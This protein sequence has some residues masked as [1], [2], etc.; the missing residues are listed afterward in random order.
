MDAEERP[1]QPD[2]MARIPPSQ[3][4]NVAFRA[5][6]EQ[7]DQDERRHRIGRVTAGEARAVGG[8]RVGI[9]RRARALVGEFDRLNRA[10]LD[11]GR[12]NSN[13]A[14]L[15]GGGT[16]GQRRHRVARI[17][18]GAPP[19]WVTTTAAATGPESRG[20]GPRALDDRHVDGLRGRRSSQAT[21]TR[22]P[23]SSACRP[24]KG[25]HFHRP[26]KRCLTGFVYRSARWTKAPRARTGE[27]A[28][29]TC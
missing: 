29:R 14:V 7:S 13:A 10:S 16:T 4:P 17:T 26:L 1:G 22:Q 20:G 19:A 3:G 24:R 18:P 2:D 28:G 25:R 9:D 12:G 11:Q 8:D 21:G 5:G 27:T 23:G 6:D 15:A